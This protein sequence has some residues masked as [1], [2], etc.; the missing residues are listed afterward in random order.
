MTLSGPPSACT[1]LTVDHQRTRE[2]SI[3]VRWNRP[4]ITGRRD[5][6]YNIHHSNPD[7]PGNFTK[8]NTNPYISTTP[9]L[10]YTVSGL[11]PLT[12]YTI[13]VTVHNGVSDQDLAGEEKRWCEVTATSGEMRKLY[14]LRSS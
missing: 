5:Y 1:G 11:R 3:T 12:N 7:L 2:N 10:Q 14:L 8:F 9:F 13:R 6:F 4:A